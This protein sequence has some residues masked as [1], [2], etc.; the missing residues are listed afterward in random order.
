M[1]DR[2]SHIPTRRPHLGYRPKTEIRAKI[3]SNAPT[4]SPLAPIHAAAPAGEASD[5][6]REPNE[7]QYRPGGTR[8]RSACPRPSA[9][10]GRATR[11][12]ARASSARTLAAKKTL[13]APRHRSLDE[14]HRPHTS[15]S[16]P[17]DHSGDATVSPARTWASTTARRPHTP[18][19]TLTLQKKGDRESIC[20]EVIEASTA[21]PP[22]TLPTTPTD[23]S[24]DT[25]PHT[26]PTDNTGDVK[27]QRGKARPKAANNPQ[28]IPAT[29]EQKMSTPGANLEELANLQANELQKLIE[30]LQG[31]AVARTG[32]TLEALNEFL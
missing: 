3:H 30:S 12:Q 24:G 19:P 31:I 9:S 22:A 17:T 14:A 2:D 5:P 13:A 4:S 27:H 11:S 10:R 7:Q 8:V 1:T 32:N 26:P 23:N 16:P 6:E 18:T 29:Q 20:T 25:P 21:F 28:A 15:H